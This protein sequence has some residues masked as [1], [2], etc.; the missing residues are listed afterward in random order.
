M[1]FEKLF[2]VNENGDIKG[3]KQKGTYEN[4]KIKITSNENIDKPKNKKP[5]RPSRPS[6]QMSS[7]IDI[8]TKIE[9]IN[10]D[11]EEFIRQ[12]EEKLNQ[13]DLTNKLLNLRKFLRTSL[14]SNIDKDVLY[15]FKML[16]KIMDHE[17]PNQRNKSILNKLIEKY[18]KRV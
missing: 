14:E 6:T 10:K 7:S 12:C 17:Q 2:I 16:V 9:N 13:Q 11:D 5:E 8:N 15:D 4:G 18:T 3:Y 1:N